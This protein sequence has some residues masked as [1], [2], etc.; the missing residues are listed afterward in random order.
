MGNRYHGRRSV[1][2]YIGSC[3]WPYGRHGNNKAWPEWAAIAGPNGQ[4]RKVR[5]A[6]VAG[7]AWGGR[8]R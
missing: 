6:W 2:P 3:A 7:R 1:A 8:C 5:S 4:T